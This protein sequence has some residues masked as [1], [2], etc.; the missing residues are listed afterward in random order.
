MTKLSVLRQ[1]SRDRVIQGYSSAG[2][3]TQLA[4]RHGTWSGVCVF[5]GGGGGGVVLFC[6][7][8]F[9]LFVFFW[10]VGGVVCCCFLLLLLFVVF[11]CCCFCVFFLGG[12]GSFY[13][14]LMSLY[15]AVVFQGRI[16][17]DNCKCCH[18]DIE[19]ADQT[20]YLT[21]PQYT[22]TEPTSP[23][24]DPMMPGAWP[25]SH[26]STIFYVNGMSRPGKSTQRKRELNLGLPLSRRKP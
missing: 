19:V 9:V 23:N 10:L 11:C 21:Q 5:V 13:G 25:G 3:V 12:G 14:C 24:A 16:C 1:I 20:F 15:H 6:L 18:N 2:P 22:G 17:S 26:W 8:V 7:G 4:L